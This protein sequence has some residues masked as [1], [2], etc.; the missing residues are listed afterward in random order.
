MQIVKTILS[1]SLKVG[2]HL[3]LISCTF[4]IQMK[5]QFKPIFNLDRDIDSVGNDWPSS[6]EDSLLSE[7]VCAPFC[8]SGY[9]RSLT[10]VLTFDFVSQKP[11]KANLMKMLA[12]KRKEG[13]ENILLFFFHLINARS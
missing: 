10:F 1:L 9:H 11:Q 6:E 7:A 13:I 12:S 3:Y 2:K 5:Q 8:K 4:S